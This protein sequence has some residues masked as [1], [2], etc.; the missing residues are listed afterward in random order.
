MM[1]THQI[2]FD[3][4]EW[5]NNGIGVRYKAFIQGNQRLRLV[6]FC[7]G[8]IEPDWCIHGHTGIVLEGCF[9]IDYH[10]S[11]EKYKKDDII[12][13]PGGETDKHKAILEK[14]EKV[15]LL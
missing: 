11:I 7:E 15:T 13:I 2:I 9:A 4:I 5:T 8:F 6:E 14:G 3:S 12:F 1:N 10:G